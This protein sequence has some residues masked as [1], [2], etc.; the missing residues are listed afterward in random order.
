MKVCTRCMNGRAEGSFYTDGSFPDNVCKPCI[1]RPRSVSVMTPKDRPKR[2]QT[3]F[4]KF[5]TEFQRNGQ[6]LVY[7]VA[8]DKQVKIGFS[9]DV[10]KRISQLQTGSAASVR[11]LAVAPGGRQLEQD[12]HQRLKGARVRGEWF[13]AKC[14]DIVPTFAALPG[15]MVFLPG[16]LT[17]EMPQLDVS[18]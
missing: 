17:E 7:L 11:L 16:Y 9:T 6:S 14:K 15:A 3:A 1:H 12:L 4:R 2:A 13:R 18:E 10:H 8:V 5:L